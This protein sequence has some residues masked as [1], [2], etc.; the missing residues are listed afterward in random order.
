MIFSNIKK[1]NNQASQSALLKGFTGLFLFFS[2]SILVRF[3]GETAYGIWVLLFGFFQWGLYFDFGITNVLKSKIPELNAKNLHQ[4]ANQYINES[5]KLTILIGVLLFL[6]FFLVF[7][8]INVSSFFNLGF[9]HKFSQ[10][11]FLLNAFLFC[12]NFVLSINKSLYIGV[13]KPVLSELSTTLTQF[14]FLVVLAAAFLVFP[15]LNVE[16]KLL[17]VT[18]LNGGLTILISLFFLIYFF[19]KNPYRVNLNLSIDYKFTKNLFKN[20]FEFMLIQFFMVIVFF[21]DTYLIARYLDTQS[22]SVFDVLNKLYQLPLLVT[23]AGISTLWPFFAKR[24][25]Q[26]D[27]EWLK[28]T[29]HKFDLFFLLLCLSIFVFS[30]FSPFIFKLW[31][32]EDLSQLI[33]YTFIILMTFIVLGRVYFTFFAVFLNGINQLKSQILVMGISAVIKI[34][35]SILIFNLGY[36][37][38][39]I[40]FLL[41]IFMLS[42]S[43]IFKF[44]SNQIIDKLILASRK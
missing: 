43:I 21:A 12:V 19:M 11:L 31:L 5:I 27:F 17:L 37:I 28:K 42:W 24:F 20:G 4:E 32:S 38:N 3:L 15:S 35:L 30:L 44:K 26:Q 10:Q 41:L 7:S 18:F 23:T 22:V 34:P 14:V 8:L 6:V 13:L 33:T 1:Y 9:T 25:H 39:G 40:L 29:F 2:I 16:Q 36:G